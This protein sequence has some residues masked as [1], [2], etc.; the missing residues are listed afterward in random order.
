LNGSQ[1]L[2]SQ[3]FQNIRFE[4]NTVI[5]HTGASLATTVY[6][7]YLISGAGYLSIRD[8][9]TENGLVVRMDN[10]WV[11]SAGVGAE[12]S[13]LSVN[14]QHSYADVGSVASVK[15]STFAI[16]SHISVSN[17]AGSLPRHIDTGNAGAVLLG[18]VNPADIF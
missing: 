6:P 5:T 16:L 17:A 15:L 14:S 8:H 13:N 9:Y 1:A 7:I 2:V 4:H 11:G 10:A 3:G 12:I 18:Y